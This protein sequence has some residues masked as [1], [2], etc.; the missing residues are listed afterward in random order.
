[1]Q[2]LI[3]VGNTRIKWALLESGALMAQD[4]AVHRGELDAAL[5]MLDAALPSNV[6]RAVVANVAGAA[7]ATRLREL[8]ERRGVAVEIVASTAARCGVRCAY[9]DP[10]RLGVDRWLAVI[11]AY[12]AARGAACVVSAGTA[13]T[14]DAVDAA[15]RHLG[16]L[17]VPGTRLMAAA[18]ERETSNIGSTPPAQGVPRGI[19]VLG[20]DTATAVGHGTMLALAAAVDRAAARVAAVLGAPPRL[21]LTGGDGALLQ[22]WLETSAELRADLVLEGLALVAAAP[23]ESDA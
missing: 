7:L 19:D 15:G 23:E 10:S 8:L 12:G 6:T 20:R 17:I 18:L 2:A 22:P 11:A 13:A 21:Y 9:A 4:G 3:D 16:G 1:M 5:A 14:F